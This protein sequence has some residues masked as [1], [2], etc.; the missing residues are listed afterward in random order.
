MRM[1][2]LLLFTTIFASAG[3]GVFFPGPCSNFQP[4]ILYCMMLVLFLSF[5]KINFRSL[6]DTSTIALRRLGVLAFVKLLI[7]PASLYWITLL[8]LPDYAIP[9]LLLSGISTG[10][11]GPFIATLVDADVTQVLKMVIVTSLI[12]PFSLPP[13]VKVLAGANMTIPIWEMI[14]LLVIVVFVPISAVL[15]V[16]RFFP[17]ALEK[18][19]T[20]H[21]PI[22]LVMF[23][24]IN[25]GV[26][27]KYSDFFFQN[28][29]QLLLCLLVAYVLSVIYYASGFLVAWKRDYPEKLAAGISMGIMN[30]VLVIVFSSRFFGPLAPTLAALYMFPFFTMI[31]PL[32]MLAHSSQ[33]KE[34]AKL[35]SA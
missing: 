26:F 7:L 32:R 30:N 14:R 3:I 25:L 20:R 15:F 29:E 19:M 6:F 27:S 10:V 18:I 11:V 2:D 9:V 22:S 28:P 13:L 33:S 31:I 35:E 24:I 12:V 34:Q 17:N 21:Y 16:R 5:L 4:Y 23:S 1:D 8:I